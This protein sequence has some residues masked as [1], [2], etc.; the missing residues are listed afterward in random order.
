[1]SRPTR[2]FRSARVSL[3]FF[4]ASKVPIAAPATPA[5]SSIREVFVLDMAMVFEKSVPGSHTATVPI[6]DV[7]LNTRVIIEEMTAPIGPGRTRMPVPDRGVRYPIHAVHPR[8]AI[9]G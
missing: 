6:T 8:S 3:P 9:M 1:M 7:A 2:S 4:G 5:A